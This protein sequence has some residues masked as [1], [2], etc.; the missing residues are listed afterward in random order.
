MYKTQQVRHYVPH[1]GRWGFNGLSGHENN[2]PKISAKQRRSDVAYRREAIG[3]TPS[4]L[5]I[6]KRETR[7]DAVPGSFNFPTVTLCII[8]LSRRLET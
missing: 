7:R 4:I 8:Q 6:V 1:I 2:A 5:I 3:S